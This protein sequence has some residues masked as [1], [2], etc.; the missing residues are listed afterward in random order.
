MYDRFLEVQEK[1]YDRE[2]AEWDAF[3]ANH[4]DGSILQTT[5]W[6]RLKSR[7]GWRSQRIWL[8]KDGK[9]VAGGQMLI[10]SAALGLI[11]AAYIPHGPLVDWQ[12]SDQVSVLFNQ[13]DIAAYE[14][15]AAFLKLE[16]RIWQTEN[17]TDQWQ[18][19]YLSQG[20]SKSI[21]TIQPPRTAIIDLRPGEEDILA[22]MKQK[23]RYNIRLAEKKGV[24]V[25][26]GSIEDVAVFN[27]LIQMTG[28]RNAFGVHSPRYYQAAYD[29]F[30]PENGALLIAEYQNNPL[31]VVMVFKCG[32]RAAYLYGASSGE[33]RNRMPT[34][35]VQWAAIQWAKAH[36][37]S[38]Y[39]LWGIPDYPPEVLESEFHK[40]NDGLWGVYRFKRGFGGEVRRAVDPI[41]RVYNK[42]V[43]RLY[44]RLQAR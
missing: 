27:Q 18:A 41:D 29:L 12:D 8:R 9:L 43:Y 35:A 31:A 28:N 23:T 32:S 6:A 42:L 21:D 37:C 33:E 11:R 15:R 22:T 30:M 2:D 44:I 10:R 19:I 5:S 14:Q 20:S 26:V 4:P 3:V 40:H 13:L 1:P 34:Y 17:S 25:R 39:D 38:E 7:F 24:T 36:D 16:P